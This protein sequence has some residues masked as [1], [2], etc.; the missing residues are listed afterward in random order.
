[1]IAEYLQTGPGLRL[2]TNILSFYSVVCQP[3]LSFN[4][5]N[6]ASTDKNFNKILTGFLCENPTPEVK[7]LAGLLES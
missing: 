2:T 4:R 6:I 3:D 1:M 7:I 5:V